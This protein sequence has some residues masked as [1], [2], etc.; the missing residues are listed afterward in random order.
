MF[1]ENILKSSRPRR[2]SDDPKVEQSVI[3]V[4]ELVIVFRRCRLVFPRRPSPSQDAPRVSPDP[5]ISSAGWP[6]SWI[7]QLVY[8]NNKQQTC[9]RLLPPPQMPLLFPTFSISF[10]RSLVFFCLP[11]GGSRN[12]MRDRRDTV[13]I[14]SVVHSDSSG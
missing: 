11:E 12:Y 2:V 13:W 4:S 14:H 7:R 6:R 3:N 8:Q 5:K 1:A 9:V 10:S